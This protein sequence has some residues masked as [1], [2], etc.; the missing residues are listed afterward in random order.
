MKAIA[1]HPRFLIPP[2]DGQH[3]GD[4]G[5]RTMKGGVETGYLRQLRITTAKQPDKLYFSRQMIGVIG[6]DLPQ[7]L[8]QHVVDE[9]SL[10]VLKTMHHPV[11]CGRQWKSPLLL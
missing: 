2:G 10:P 9:S 1:L 11:T 3:P 8:Q 6:A 4:P 7:V 5:Q